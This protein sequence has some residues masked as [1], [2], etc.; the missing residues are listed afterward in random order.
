M[1]ITLTLDKKELPSPT[2]GLDIKD[3]LLSLA[4]NTL[5]KQRSQSHLKV[6]ETKGMRQLLTRL[7]PSRIEMEISLA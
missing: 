6:K 7:Q 5:P 4:T 3:H 2:S 1:I